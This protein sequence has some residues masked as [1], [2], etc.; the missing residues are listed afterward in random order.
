MRLLPSVAVLDRA[1][2]ASK[3]LTFISTC[4]YS[5]GDTLFITVDVGDCLKLLNTIDIGDSHELLA[6][7]GIIRST[8][9]SGHAADIEAN[10]DP[11]CD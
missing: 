1:Q 8:D 3:V 6:G 7:W 2:A 4:S 10:P 5:Y 11:H 9:W